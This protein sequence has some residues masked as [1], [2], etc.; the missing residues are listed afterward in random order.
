M[1][2]WSFCLLTF[3]QCVAGLIVSTLCR[4]FVLDLNRELALRD[5]GRDRG[6]IQTGWG[7]ARRGGER[8]RPKKRSGV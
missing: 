3:V 6:V 8:E 2:F 4:D 7:T 1:L 5:R